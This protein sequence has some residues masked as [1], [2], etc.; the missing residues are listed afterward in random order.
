MGQE[1]AG[2]RG[3]KLWTMVAVVLGSGIVFLDTSVVNLALPKIADELPRGAFA[4]LEVQGYVQNGYFVTLSALLILAGALTDYYG[5]RKVFAIGLAGFGLTSL[6]C[7]LAPNAQLL[8]AFRILQGAA[9]A[10][11]VP[12]SLSIIASSFDG[13]EQG[14]AFGVW[15][16]ASAATT[17]IGPFLGGLLVDTVSWRAAFLINVPLILIAL[18]ATLRHVPES[19]DEQATGRFDWVGS[20]IVIVAVAGLSFGPVRGQQSQWQDLAVPLLSMGIGL[21]AAIAFPF[22]MKRA[23]DPLVPLDL[24]RSRN[25]SITNISTFV[26]YGALYVVLGFMG[27]FFIGTL[28]YSE[29]AAG[30]ATIP[31]TVLLVLFSGR[32]GK[33]S[34][35]FGPRFFMSAGPAI[36][37]VGLL[38]FLRFPDGHAGW[39]LGAG[40]GQSLLPPLDY[41][42]DVFPGVLVFGAGLMMMVAPLTTALMTSLPKRKSGLA[43]AINN[44]ISRVGS[45]IVF[46]VIFVVM[47]AGFYGSVQERVPDAP[48]DQPS[49]RR[50]VSPLNPPPEGVSPEL[51]EATQEAST[52]SFR[53]AMLVASL[54]LLAGAAVNAAGISNRQ[55]IEYPHAEPGERRTREE[56]EAAEPEP[57]ELAPAPAC[58]VCGEEGTVSAHG[59]RVEL[60]TPE[61]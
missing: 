21:A 12:A 55:A 57:H 14:R 58:V 5:R 17:I 37:G 53:L 31:A 1:P 47:A 15:A 11:V 60:D 6:L 20:L 36:M 38:W 25:F 29:P 24:F 34:A 8:I 61:K 10:F 56:E 27:I 54:M 7:G 19:R 30:L 52:D 28:G 9:G 22:V 43:S 35:R 48:V 13:E 18:Y 51:L 2:F 45:P 44:A 49:F 59:H 33:L 3:W 50:D 41:W 39:D 4:K 23:R 40:A 32:F 26:I 42:V 16:A 46:A